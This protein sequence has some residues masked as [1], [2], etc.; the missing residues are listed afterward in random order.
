MDTSKVE[1][2][3]CTDPAH[4]HGPAGCQVGVAL[5]ISEEDLIALMGEETVKALKAGVIQ[6]GGSYAAPF[7][8]VDAS[9][10]DPQWPLAN[11]MFGPLDTGP[12]PHE[13]LPTLDE[14]TK[15]VGKVANE[16]REA[17][18]PAGAVMFAHPV[19]VNRLLMIEM[20]S[21][22]TEP[23]GGESETHLR[24][25]HAHDMLLDR[26]ARAIFT[27]AEEIIDLIESMAELFDRRVRR[28]R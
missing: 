1:P 8:D 15:L 3:V 21:I 13:V 6:A 16:D 4:N 28:G 24:L 12:I 23:K 11:P 17:E 18:R 20:E 25:R 5:T 27:D 26:A 9:G 19:S 10:P 2:L 14:Y 7:A 22:A